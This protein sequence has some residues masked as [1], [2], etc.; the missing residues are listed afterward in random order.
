MRSSQSHGSPGACRLGC[1]QSPCKIPYPYDAS[2]A[3]WTSL[4]QF[5]I[6]C[7]ARFNMKQKNKDSKK[8]VP[9]DAL[10]SSCDTMQPLTPA[11]SQDGGAAANSSSAGANG[12]RTLEAVVAFADV[13]G[14]G[15]SDCDRHGDSAVG[16][17]CAAPPRRSEMGSKLCPACSQ[18]NLL[19]HLSCVLCGAKFSAGRPVEKEVQ[20][21]GYPLEGPSGALN[22]PAQR[23]LPASCRWRTHPSCSCSGGA[24]TTATPSSC[25]TPS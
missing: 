1:L 13:H 18:A 9:C 19:S 14:N 25:A 10:P 6:S 24:A 5:C 11:R 7:G 21:R 23:D 15:I 17:G 4:A 12:P 16:G 22:L 3:L 20:S 8:R 2:C